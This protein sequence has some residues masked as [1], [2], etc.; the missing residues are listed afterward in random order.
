[1][2]RVIDPDE[3][4]AV[5][6]T[7]DDLA[8]HGLHVSPDL[9]SVTYWLADVADRERG[10]GRRSETFRAMDEVRRL[11]GEAW[12][13]LGD[14]DLATHLVRTELLWQGIPLSTA[15]KQIAGG[16][17]VSCRILPM[18][19]DRVETRI[20]AVDER[21]GS[22]DLHFQEYWVARGA[23]DEVKGVR[24]EGAERAVPAPGVIE[25]VIEADVVLICPSNPVA[26][27]GPILSVPAIADAVRGRGGTVAG[28]SPIVGGAPL[29]G[30]A[31]RLMPSAGLEVSAFGAA[32]AYRGLCSGF[33]IDRRDA[34]L[35]PRI[36]D[37]LGMRVAVIDTVMADDDSAER[38]ARTALDV[39][40]T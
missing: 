33:V 1:V 32:S 5:V 12:F 7:G 11:G 10:W 9:D 27:I 22:L 40:A 38:V 30:M 14:A 26:S 37:E 8:L 29:R 13:S 20:D 19:D 31:D 28:V 23:R 6:N 15:T 36:E 18:T 34:P 4:T 21:G 39:A 16:L 17:G 3:L 35:A 24:Y 2:A 25:A